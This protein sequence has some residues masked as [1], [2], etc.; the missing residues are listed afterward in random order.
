MPHLDSAPTFAICSSFDPSAWAGVTLFNRGGTNVVGSTDWTSPV[1]DAITFLNGR[2]SEV[3]NT[4]SEQLLYEIA[5]NAIPGTWAVSLERTD[6]LRVQVSGAGAAPFSLGPVA[7]TADWAGLGGTVNSSL[8]LGVHIVD[9]PLNW[10]RGNV[11]NPILQFTSG[12]SSFKAPAASV[13]QRVQDVPV[14]MRLLGNGDADDTYPTLNLAVLD[15]A[16]NDAIYKRIRWGVDNSG[17][18]YCTYP[19]GINDIT[20]TSTT[21]RDRLGFTGLVANLGRDT[22]SYN[23]S[24][25][26]Y[27][28]TAANPLPGVLVPSRPIENQEYIVDVVGSSRRTI[29]NGWVSNQVGSYRGETITF[30]VDG[31]ADIKDLTRHFTDHFIG[32]LGTGTRVNLYQDWGDSR[33]ALAEYDVD[34]SQRAYDLLYTSEDNG[35]RGRVRANM[36]SAGPY[37]LTYPQR[38]RRRSPITIQI[39]EIDG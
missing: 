7:G 20:W 34:D 12:A 26:L 22:L 31:P 27:T 3:G 10:I 2:G 32:Y 35:F 37:Q 28:Y 14:Y 13:V 5:A 39:E 6:K 11:D 36:V 8:V 17:H 30:Y 25:G 1:E 29:S 21:F 33:R 16:A 15:N 24:I 23:G 9:M 38:L 18:V 4:F 19:N